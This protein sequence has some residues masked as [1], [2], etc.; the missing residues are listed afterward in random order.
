MHAGEQA[1]TIG[2]KVRLM[3]SVPE[4]NLEN[5]GSKVKSNTSDR[6]IPEQQPPA[7]SLH[8]VTDEK[9]KQTASF[10][11]KRVSA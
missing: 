9:G 10:R 7:Y 8:C 4:G 1:S 11:H 2:Y 5:T 3:A 6:G